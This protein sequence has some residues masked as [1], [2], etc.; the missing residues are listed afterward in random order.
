MSLHKAK[1]NFAY[2]GKWVNDV[3]VTYPCQ[4][5]PCANLIS[6]KVNRKSAKIA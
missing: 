4:N 2:S 5:Q 3:L 1:A 6:R